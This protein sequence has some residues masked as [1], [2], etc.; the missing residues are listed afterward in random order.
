MYWNVF[1]LYFYQGIIL[2]KFIGVGD[3]LELLEALISGLKNGI[4]TYVSIHTRDVSILLIKGVA[5]DR[6]D[7]HVSI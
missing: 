4:A 1:D 5:S 2:W 6:S 7:T 3:H